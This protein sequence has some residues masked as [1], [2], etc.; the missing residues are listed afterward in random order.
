MVLDTTS[1]LGRRPRKL[2]LFVSLV[3]VALSATN[4]LLMVRQFSANSLEGEVGR[5]IEGLAYPPPSDAVPEEIMNRTHAVNTNTTASPTPRNINTTA[6]TTQPST[7]QGTIVIQLMGELGNHLNSFSFYFA[8]RTIASTEFNLNLTLHVRKQNQLKAT[9]AAQN[10]QCL[11]SFWNLDFDECDWLQDN[12]RKGELCKNKISIQSGAL[13]GLMKSSNNHTITKLAQSLQMSSTTS[14]GIRSFLRDYV[15][16]LKDESILELY[17]RRGVGW[18]I[19]EPYPFLYNTERIGAPDS[20]INEFYSRG[21][22]EYL[23]FDSD[24]KISS[25]CCSMLPEKDEQVF[26]YRSFVVD[27]PRRHLSWGGAELTPEK[28]AT[29]LS[30]SLSPG[31]KIA[32]VSGRSTQHRVTAYKNAFSNRSFVVREIAGQSAIQDFCFLAHAQ[33]GLWGTVQSTYVGWASLISK[34]LQNATIYGVNYPARDVNITSRVPTNGDLARI[35]HYPVFDL[36]DED[37]W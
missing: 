25:G 4:C 10:V 35:V 13:F 24:T 7:L 9:T 28:S 31:T 34:E 15:A 33:A 1:A 36:L 27:L 18:T 8:V 19:D 21:L 14:D 12:G 3:V 23:A 22:Q 29:L 6:S 20:L 26:H 16:I 32:L 30:A 11:K 2:C 37:V 5:W 17:R